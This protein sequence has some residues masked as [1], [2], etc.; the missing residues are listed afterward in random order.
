MV[1]LTGWMSGELIGCWAGGWWACGLGNRLLDW[2][3]GWMVDWRLLGWL[4][5]RLETGGMVGW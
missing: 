5:G 4:G 1:G 3:A 2:W